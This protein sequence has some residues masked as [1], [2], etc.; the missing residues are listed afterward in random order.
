MCLVNKEQV[1]EKPTAQKV[2]VTGFIVRCELLAK[3]HSNRRSKI[4][5]FWY[6]DMEVH[7]KPKLD[8]HQF[9]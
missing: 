8:D 2:F 3:P 4:E 9:E 5:T 7:L 1:M 6:K